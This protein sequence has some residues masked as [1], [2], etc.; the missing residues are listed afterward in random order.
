MIIKL[1][2]IADDKLGNKDAK[3]IEGVRMDT[4]E[5]WSRKIFA[6]NRVLRGQLEQFGIGDMMNV[7]MVRQGQYWNVSG[8]EVA[9]KELVDKVKNSSATQQQG[10][11]G[12]ANT[13]KSTWNGRTGEAYDRSS[14]IY[15]AMDWLK[16]S[17]DG[18]IESKH[19]SALFGIAKDVYEYIHNGVNPTVDPLDPPVEEE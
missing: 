2:A 17:T 13:V 9:S 15:L 16:S 8:L 11:G 3:R 18:P 19:Y 1:T 12:S 4:G 14:A 5:P 6:D 10:A 7:K